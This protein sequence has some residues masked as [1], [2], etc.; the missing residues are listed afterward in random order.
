MTAPAVGVI[1]GAMRFLGQNTTAMCGLTILVIV[2]LLVA[3]GPLV[4]PYSPTK[5]VYAELLRPPSL[6]HPFGT[7]SFGRDVFTRVLYGARISIFC[8]M[9]G[10]VVGAAIGTWI[11][12]ASGYYGGWY[13]GVIMSAADLLIS[14]PSFV[15]A[16]FLMFVFGFGL[17]ERGV[18]DRARLFAWLRAARPQYDDAGERRTL[19]PGREARRSVVAAHHAGGDFPEHCGA[20]VGAHDDGICV[21]RNDRGRVEFP[22]SRHTAAHPVPRRDNV[23]RERILPTRALGSDL[24]RNCGLLRSAWT[25]PFWRWL[26]RPARPQ[27][28]AEDRQLTEVVLDIRDLRTSLRLSS[29]TK[30]EILHGIDLTVRRGDVLGLI[31]ESGSGKTM[32]G[33]SI[34]RLLPPFGH[35]RSKRLQFLTQELSEL[36]D[37]QLRS[38]RGRRIAMVFQ[39]PVGAFN[40][41]KSIAWHLR[42]ALLCADAGHIGS[43]VGPKKSAKERIVG[44]LKSVGIVGGQTVMRNYPHQLSGGMLQR[45]LIA[46]AIACEPEPDHRRRAD[47]QSGCACREANS[48]PL[49]RSLAQSARGLSLHYARHCSR[50][51]ALQPNRRNVRRPNRR[52]RPDFGSLRRPPSSLHARPACD[53]SR[54]ERS[55]RSLAGNS[56]R[57]TRAR[58]KRCRDAFSNRV[59][60]SPCLDAR[61]RC[62]RLSKRTQATPCVACY[63]RKVEFRALLGPRPDCQLSGEGRS[64]RTSRPRR[65]R[66][67]CG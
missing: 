36:S 26:E 64:C 1:R 29:S 19:Y 17:V 3:F 67:A 44:L 16:L 21:W 30:V 35:I 34:M 11:G 20:A 12:L 22:R 10:I 59:A 53:I 50:S 27:T 56:R 61:A 66:P 45:V 65:A 15:L 62:R 37:R 55:R 31:G 25:E 43:E 63:A 18:G 48:G 9:L 46:M 14:F 4:S 13:D 60:A 42:L 28:S 57:A 6:V 49:S 51:F 24:D 39:D 23:R 47:H 32:T 2:I 41:A 38:L 52:A 7:D 54:T 58:P 5:T 40:P 33:L 8:S